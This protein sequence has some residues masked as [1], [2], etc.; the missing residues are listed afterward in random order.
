MPG[1]EA[2]PETEP[3]SIEPLHHLNLAAG[4]DSLPRPR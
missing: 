1:T 2:P 4:L 3:G